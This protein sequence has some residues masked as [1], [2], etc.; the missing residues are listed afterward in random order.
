ME[1]QDKDNAC[2][3]S[4]EKKRKKDT[5]TI[6]YEKGYRT[7]AQ[8]RCY[9]VAQKMSWNST[10]TNENMIDPMIYLIPFTQVPD[11]KYDFHFTRDTVF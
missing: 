7:H 9:C 8:L 5:L 11:V 6:F 3:D 10:K 4:T 1:Q 2:L